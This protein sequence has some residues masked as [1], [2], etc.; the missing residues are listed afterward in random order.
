MTIALFAAL[1]GCG[2]G[3]THPDPP[4]LGEISTITSVRQV[5][6]PIDAYLPTAS[7][8]LIAQRAVYL[9]SA[10]CLR[11]LGISEAPWAAPA[12]TEATD[13]DVRSQLYGYFAPDR[14]AT[15]GYDAITATDTR[16][17]ASATTQ[18]VLAGRDSTGAPLTQYQGKAVP[19]G[20]CLKEALDAVGGSMAM[21][22]DPSALPGGGP[23]VPLT[24]P[25]I[26]AADHQWSGCMK[27][28]GFTYAN[29]ADAYMDPRWRDQNPGAGAAVTHSPAEIA[30][31]TADDA[32]KRSTNLM[33]IAVAVQTA[34][35]QQY[36]A[37]HAD[38]LAKFAQRVKQHI[39]DC[40]KLIAAGDAA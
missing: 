9:T 27:T 5:V 38:D 2:A 21:T 10:R 31:A 35:D 18:Q 26:V 8:G 1:A 40:E 39:A 36:I 25:R 32:C 14:V 15:T 23:K 11:R 17:P 7:Q 37:A 20:G 33:G 6:R 19:K 34:Y 28:H 3:G 12:Q 4:Q 29:P 30:T 22:P 13:Q 16:T 24:D